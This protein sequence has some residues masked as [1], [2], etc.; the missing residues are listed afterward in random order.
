M[1]SASRKR[2]A[3][4]YPAGDNVKFFVVARPT[5]ADRAPYQEAETRDVQALRDRGVIEQLYVRLDGSISYT[6]V[7]AESEE[8]ARAAF[9]QLPFIR[10]GVLTIELFPVR[11]A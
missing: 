6:V 9:E 5:A 7:E 10:N 1:A 3:S 4:I 11:V 8:V 2:G